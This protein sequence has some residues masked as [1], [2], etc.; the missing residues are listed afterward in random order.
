MAAWL[1]MPNLIRFG[2]SEWRAWVERYRWFCWRR[3]W[4]TRGVLF[5]P[6]VILRLP[7]TARLDIGSG[8]SIG[9][10]T[11]L[12]L[13]S[14]P[15]AADGQA[16]RLLIGA[17]V[18]VNEF[19]N[20]RPAGSTICIGDGCLIAQFVTIVGSNHALAADRWLRDQPWAAAPRG[21]TVGTDVWIGAGA[22]LLPGVTVGNGSVVGAG[23]VVTAD[24]PPGAIVGG[25]PARVIG[26]RG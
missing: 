25:V 20:I 8:T 16:S 21:V 6:T 19:N 12:D 26:Q 23:A 4:Q 18:A 5:D 2:M 10:Y 11:V 7:P 24:V 3:D 17:R 15:L 9:A 14:D 1:V 13:L 22:T